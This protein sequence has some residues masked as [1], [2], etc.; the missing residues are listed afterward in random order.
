MFVLRRQRGRLGS[1]VRREKRQLKTA[2]M[3]NLFNA[4]CMQVE[5]QKQEKM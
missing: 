3:S 5:G 4:E 2:L 1:V